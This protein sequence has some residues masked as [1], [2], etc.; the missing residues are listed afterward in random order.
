MDYDDVVWVGDEV[1]HPPADFP[2]LLQPCPYV[3]RPASNPNPNTSNA[4]TL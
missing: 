1:A 2:T 4:S 3:P